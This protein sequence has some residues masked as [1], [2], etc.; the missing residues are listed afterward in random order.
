MTLSELKEKIRQTK[1]IELAE[2][3][4]EDYLKENPN[5]VEG[6]LWL[7]LV[8]LEIPLV[9]MYRSMECLEKVWELDP[10]HFPSLILASYIMDT[11]LGGVDA[12][13]FDKLNRFP[14]ERLTK[15]EQGILEMAK[16]WHYRF[17]N[18]AEYERI[19]CFLLN[20]H[21]KWYRTITN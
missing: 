6:W 13:L 15:E 4:V 14:T 18:K 10:F 2:E 1:E 7:A 8:E 20:W 21:L 19:Y 11:M 17:T 3:L 5:S 12:K 9:D 16:G